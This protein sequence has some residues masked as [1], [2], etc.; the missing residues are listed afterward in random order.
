MLEALCSRNKYSSA[1]LLFPWR[2]KHPAI[3]GSIKGQ[4]RKPRLA[5]PRQHHDT[6]WKDVVTRHLFAFLEFYFPSVFREIDTV[7]PPRFLDKE[8]SRIIR[9]QSIPDRY[10]DLLVE[11]RRATGSSRMVCHVEVQ[12]SPV[13]DFEHRLF[14]YA[15][16]I[17]DKVGVFP[18]TL[19]VL[20]DPRTHFRVQPFRAGVP[21]AELRLEFLSVKLLDYH[22]S[23]EDLWQMQT[24]FSA[25]TAIHLAV[26]RTDGEVRGLQSDGRALRWFQTKLDLMRRIVRAGFDAACSADLLAFLDWLIALPPDLDAA[27]LQETRTELGEETMP[28]VTSWERIATKRGYSAGQAAGREHGLA[29]G[30]AE[31]LAE[32]EA[33]GRAAGELTARRDILLRL[34][35]RRFVVTAD[36]HA[37]VS[38]CRDCDLLTTA[39]DR[40]VDASSATEVLACLRAPSANPDEA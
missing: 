36:Q 13:A 1:T 40:V 3:W 28:Y 5:T 23:G 32:G 24:L 4:E 37:A 15:Y 12:G 20:T 10:A 17:Y 30:H 16:R 33:Q 7:T 38:A 26:Q 27:L 19:V 14:Q 21:G 22:K 9:T 31:G 29:E 25:V 2:R 35:E 34:L 39:I 11:V 18:L 6:A 8:L